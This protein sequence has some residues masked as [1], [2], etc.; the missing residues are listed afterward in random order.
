MSELSGLELH[1][2]RSDAEIAR[3]KQLEL[4]KGIVKRLQNLPV[5]NGSKAFDIIW[6]GVDVIQGYEA[7]LETAQ[8]RNKVLKSRLAVLEARL[9][10]YFVVGGDQ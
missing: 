10:E 3:D 9:D 5:P 1:M 2:F 7:E 6:E 8:E 4:R